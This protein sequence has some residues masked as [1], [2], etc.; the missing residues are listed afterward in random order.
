MSDGRATSE[1]CPLL[2]QAG[3]HP[4]SPPG[5]SPGA[6]AAVTAA[7]APLQPQDPV[8]PCPELQGPSDQLPPH[9]GPGPPTLPPT[10]QPLPLSCGTRCPHLLGQLLLLSQSSLSTNP[11]D[12]APCP[13][14]GQA[15]LAGLPEL[16]FS[17]I[18]FSNNLFFLKKHLKV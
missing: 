7:Q 3:A 8:H 10:A 15:T 12:G 1:W 9:S 11:W 5:S 14:P 17:F 4:D 6:S 13:L 16:P 18:L 2:A